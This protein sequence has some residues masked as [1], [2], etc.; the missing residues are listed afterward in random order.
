MNINLTKKIFQYAPDNYTIRR[1]T[2]YV[3]FV[4]FIAPN[5]IDFIDIGW[6]PNGQTK[7]IIFGKATTIF[8]QEVELLDVITERH[9]PSHLGP[10]AMFFDVNGNVQTIGYW[11]NGHLHRPS[12]DGPAFYSYARHVAEYWENGHLVKPPRS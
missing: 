3:D 12:E 4:F 10:A 9:R 5:N 8:Y 2:H 7:W 11:T 6:H 1:P